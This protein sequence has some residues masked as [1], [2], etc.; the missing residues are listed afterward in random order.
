MKRTLAII[1][2]A[3]TEHGPGY[4]AFS[5]G[6]DSTVLL[7][8][9]YASTRH[10][11]PLVYVDAQNDYPGTLEHIQACAARY[12]ADLHAIRATKP[13]LTQWTRTGWPI[14]SASLITAR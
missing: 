13:I 10:R 3:M 9:V 1:D 7:D 8:L 4:L 5:G 12:H 14:G 6:T 11:P 2:Q